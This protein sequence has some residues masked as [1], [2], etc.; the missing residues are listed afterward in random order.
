LLG[1]KLV[2]IR[3]DVVLVEDAYHACPINEGLGYTLRVYFFHAK[4]SD[5]EY[6]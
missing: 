1:G 2:D 4:F 6:I 3:N 5:E